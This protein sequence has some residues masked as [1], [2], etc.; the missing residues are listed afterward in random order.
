MVRTP[1]ASAALFLVL[2]VPASASAVQT[3]TCPLPPPDGAGFYGL[4]VRGISCATGKAIIRKIERGQSTPA[5]DSGFRVRL[6]GRTWR[7]TTTFPAYEQARN[8]CRNGI[9]RAW[10]RSGA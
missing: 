9:R 1:L 5:G 4:K 7:C 2:L 10:L 3:K 6:N 8:T